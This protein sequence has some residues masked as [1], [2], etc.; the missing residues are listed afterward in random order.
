MG[1]PSRVNH[2]TISTSDGR[3]GG[4]RKQCVRYEPYY[5]FMLVKEPQKPSCVYLLPSSELNRVWVRV[6]DLT[7]PLGIDA[8]LSNTM[9][10]FY[11]GKCGCACLSH[12]SIEVSTS[13]PSAGQSGRRMAA[14]RFALISPDTRVGDVILQNPST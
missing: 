5:N 6:D 7:A 9:G 12:K 2:G 10:A 11:N 1:I 13:R 8:L 3:G 4:K 14:G